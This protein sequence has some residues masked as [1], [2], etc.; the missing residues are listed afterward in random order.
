MGHCG[1]VVTVD[2]NEKL[3]K[4]RGDHD[5]EQTMGFAC[6]KGL[7]AP[8]AHNSSDRILQPLKR[9]PDGKFFPISREAA[10][11]EIAGK[12]ADILEQYGPESIAGYKGGGAFFTSSSVMMLNSFLTALGSAKAFSSVTIDQSSKSVAAGRVGIWPAGRIPFQKADAFLIFGG[13]PLVSLTTLGFDTRNPVKRLKEAKARGMKLIVVDPRYTETA[14]FSDIYIQPL[15][16]EDCTIVAGLIHIILGQGWQDQA[17][18]DAHV[19]HL[20]A[21]QTAVEDFNPDAVAEQA[22]I[23]VEKLWEIAD[24]FANQSFRGVA[25]SAT[26]PDMSRNANLAEHL[27]ECLNIICGR[28]LREGEV[29]ENPGVLVPMWPRR[30]QVIPAPRSWEKG[31]QSRIE[32]FGLLDGELPSGILSEEITRE[33]PGQVKCLLVHGGNP[34]SAIPD[35]NK[36]FRALKQLDLLVCIE[37]FMSTTAELA[38]YILPPTMPYERPDLPLYIYES[39]ITP[40]PYTRYTPAVAKAPDGSE[41]IDD[42][43][44]FWALAKRLGVTLMHRGAPLDMTQA[45]SSDDLLAAVV[46][47]SP[48]DF[49]QLREA[50]RGIL[51]Q[52]HKQVVEPADPHLDTC[53]SILPEDVANELQQVKNRWQEARSDAVEYPFRMSV[54]RLRDVINSSGRQLPSIRKR[55]P[56]NFAYM[57]AK[58]MEAL[59]IQDGDE[60]ILESNHGGIRVVAKRDKD[61]RCSVVSISHGFGGQPGET[62]YQRDGASTNLLISTDTDCEAIN[63]MPRMSGVPVRVSKVL[64]GNKRRQQTD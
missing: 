15:P 25:T 26:G 20:D 10:L 44:Y 49:E 24:V 60:V 28:F 59:S 36:I 30:A 12:I 63:A 32:G 48:L 47:D 22:G 4:I 39:M 2:E 18:C 53:F 29:I 8:E 11:D 21:L 6:F 35:L 38:D 31:Y 64:G 46:N 37:P 5:D 27:I 56:Y 54:R 17:F 1:M 57:N 33:G 45:P 13:N 7:N 51:L 34:A 19:D 40:V 9:M 50:E 52:D 3:L 14:K 58:D 42:A 41:V 62:D 61:L 23:P 16:G 55:L 43:Y